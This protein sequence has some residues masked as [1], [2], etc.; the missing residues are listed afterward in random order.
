MND[1]AAGLSAGRE[2]S[3]SMARRSIEDGFKAE[4]G[5]SPK[6]YLN[7]RHEERQQGRDFSGVFSRDR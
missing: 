2:V 7:E 6:E 3:H 4:F 5:K 1:M